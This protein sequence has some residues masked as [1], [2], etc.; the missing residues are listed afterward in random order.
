MK[1]F[2]PVMQVCGVWLLMCGRAVAGEFINLDFNQPK[3]DN[4]TLDGERN[5]WYGDPRDVFQGWEIT[6]DGAPVDRAWVLD[7]CSIPPITLS[8]FNKDTGPVYTFRFDGAP[9]SA[10][11]KTTR[12]GQTGTVPGWAYYLEF[13]LNDFDSPDPVSINGERLPMTWAPGNP[14]LRT[15]N[16]SPWAGQQ[17]ELAFE[18]R[19]GGHGILR[20]VRFTVPEPSTWALMGVGGAGL[21]WL[22]L[23]GRRR[24]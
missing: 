18:F 10:D 1:Y 3:L 21:G 7:C 15:V 12:I 14:Q 20:D 2:R 11:P 19:E 17:V 5:E 16:V 4:L 24:G 13:N 9:F 23:R 22:A 8:P 6:Q